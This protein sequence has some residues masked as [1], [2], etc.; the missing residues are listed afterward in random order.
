MTLA[1]KIVAE[2]QKTAAECHIMV[3]SAMFD[4]DHAE[5]MFWQERRRYFSMCAVDFL[6]AIL[7]ANNNSK[8]IH[9]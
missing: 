7:A 3:E 6:Q 2:E 9:S 4:G 1:E 5:A 8:R